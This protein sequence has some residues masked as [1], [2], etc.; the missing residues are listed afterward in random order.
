MKNVKIDG[1]LSRVFVLKETDDSLVYIPV[2]SLF[3]VD[4]EKLCEL[5]K[6]GGELLKVLSK[7]TLPNGRNALVQ[8]DSLIQVLRYTDEEKKQ[9]GSRLKKPDEVFAEVE[10]QAAITEAQATEQTEEQPRQRKRPGPKPGSK[11]TRAK[12]ADSAA[13]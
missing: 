2:K 1:K 5:E 11:R 3:R 6:E 4:Y 9:H 13:K 8:Y 12:P 7:T 10:Q